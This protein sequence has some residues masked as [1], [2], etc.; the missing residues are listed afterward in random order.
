MRFNFSREV[1]FVPEFDGN[2][3][4]PESEQFHVM[5]SP[6]SVG[7]CS[8]VADEFHNQTNGATEV[9]A[10]KLNIGQIQSMIRQVGDV[11]PKYVLS[12]NNL[13]DS[14]GP[15]DIGVILSFM[16]YWPLANEILAKLVE[17]SSPKE[18]DVKN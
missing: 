12:V 17:I 6:M 18:S 16:P 3:K 15:V 1:K 14:S 11:L 8:L 4:L 5:L 10:T 9:D 2:D 13:S 7:D